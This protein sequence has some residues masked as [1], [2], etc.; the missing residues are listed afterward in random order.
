MFATAARIERDLGVPSISL[1]TLTGH[2]SCAPEDYGELTDISPQG[3]GA[4]YGCLSG[5]RR[6]TPSGD[7]DSGNPAFAISR[8][9][10]GTPPL[11]PG[12]GHRFSGMLFSHAPFR[13]PV[14]HQIQRYLLSSLPAAR[15]IQQC[16]SWRTQDDEQPA[17]VR[18]GGPDR[19][20]RGQGVAAALVLARHAPEL[21]IAQGV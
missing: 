7:W 19:L 17:A 6:L 4:G 16:A 13:I 20:Q 2:R 1:N 21:V 18:P 11:T 9:P 14:S 3:P 5:G 10:P 12:H 8:G 15:A